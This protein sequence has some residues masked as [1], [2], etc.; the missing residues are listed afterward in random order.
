VSGNTAGSANESFAVRAGAGSVVFSF[1]SSLHGKYRLSIY[2]L[3]GKEVYAC[4][5]EGRNEIKINPLLGNGVY[6]AKCRQ[7]RQTNAVRFKVM[8]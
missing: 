8:N 1:P 7:G 2:D 6:L 4:S 5:G 3:S